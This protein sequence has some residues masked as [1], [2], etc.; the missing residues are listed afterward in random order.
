MSDEAEMSDRRSQ[1]IWALFEAALAHSAAERSAWLV[2]ACREDRSL[3][4]EV[5]RLLAAHERAEGILDQPIAPLAVRALSVLESA[6][7]GDRQVGPYLLGLLPGG[8]GQGPG[9][10]D[11]EC[12]IKRMTLGSIATSRSS[13]CRRTSGSTSRPSCVS[14]PKTGPR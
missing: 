9:A 4:T 11:G 8:G 5:E 10:E 3:Q 6:L 13:Y 7:V 1:E 2:D 12:S 14:S